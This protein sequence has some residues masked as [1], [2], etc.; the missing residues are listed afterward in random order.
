MIDN[1]HIL[2]IVENSTPPIDIR[3]WQEAKTVKS[4]GYEV[5]I[6]APKKAGY[7]KNWEN[8]DGINIYRHRNISSNSK[9]GQLFEYIN[10]FI[11]ELVL[12]GKIFIKHPFKLIHAANP[13]D[14]IFL[15]ALI[16]R[17][18][19]VKYIFDH[20]DLMPELYISKYTNS[21]QVIFYLLS[22][23]EKF[24]CMAADAVI[25]TNE[26]FKRHVI[27][28]H[29]II[30]RKIFVVRNDPDLNHQNFNKRKIKEKNSITKLLYLGAINAQDGVDLLIKIVHI[31][32]YKLG[33]LNIKCTVLG[34]GD[35]LVHVKMLC[36]KM[37]LNKYFE[38]LGRVKD[39]K[40]IAD[41]IR[42]SDICLETAPYNIANDKSTF[43]KVMEYMREG[44]PVVA[45]DLTETRFSTG[46]NAILVEPNNL[47]SF[48]KAINLLIKEPQI[49]EEI[50]LK[51]KNR[52]YRDLK[53]EKSQIILMNAYD[54]V[55]KRADPGY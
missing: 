22:I 8:L 9:I 23:M 27:I 50:G 13:P 46:G 15:L 48:A 41:Y 32:V 10:A 38:F 49:R 16:F 5:T 35:E 12:C 36:N 44:K 4:A 40:L 3:V 28:K 25:S 51:A 2:F 6:I 7:N 31:L 52:I 34:D 21:K 47:F 55:L 26:S 42:D 30:N 53:W 17:P 43:I 19:G 45:F 29:K 33:E 24:S 14:H 54:Y 39:R 37:G 20:H 1:K 11:Y 18:F